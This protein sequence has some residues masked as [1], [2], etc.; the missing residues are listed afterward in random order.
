MKI[1][2]KIIEL[3]LQEKLRL[4]AIIAAVKYLRALNPE[5]AAEAIRRFQSK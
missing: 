1:K 3:T 5:T 2:I 4:G